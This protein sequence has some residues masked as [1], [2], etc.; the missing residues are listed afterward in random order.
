MRD[1]L[2][3]KITEGSLLWWL[4]KGI[5]IHVARIEPGGVHTLGDSEPTPAKLVLEVRIPIQEHTKGSET[6]LADFVCVQN[7]EAEKIIEGMLE[8]RRTQ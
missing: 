1:L 7:P 4:P 6:Q 5:P 8:G 2:G 3:N